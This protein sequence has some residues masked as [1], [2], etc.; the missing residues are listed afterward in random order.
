MKLKNHAGGRQ[1]VPLQCL[2]SSHNEAIS[3]CIST[4]HAPTHAGAGQAVPCTTHACMG[5]W[6]AAPRTLSQKKQLLLIQRCQ[7]LLHQKALLTAHGPAVEVGLQL[8]NSGPH[9]GY[10]SACGGASSARACMWHQ[11]GRRDAWGEGDD[12]SLGEVPWR[13]LWVPFAQW[14][15]HCAPSAMFCRMIGQDRST[16]CAWTSMG[17]ENSVNSH[18]APCTMQRSKWCRGLAGTRWVLRAGLTS[19]NT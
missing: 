9:L 4:L 15:P 8:L 11:Q 10:L 19:S 2:R 5:A 6:R 7:L 16:S 1:A 3:R 12:F 17:D 14:E 13:T 18:A